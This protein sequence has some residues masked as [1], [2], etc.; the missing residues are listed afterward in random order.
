MK[1]AESILPIKWMQ[2]LCFLAGLYAVAVTI[3]LFVETAKPLGSRDFHQFWYAGH[4]IIQGR[5][6][7]EAFFAGEPPALPVVYLDGVTIEQYPIAQY[8]LEITP[9][10]TPMMLLLLTPFS[11][12]SWYVAKWAFLVLNLILMLVT[13]WL[14][15][16]HFPFRRIKLSLI[17][18]VLIFLVYFDL[19]ATR[20]AI[21]N[22]QTTLLVFLLMILA[23][24]YADRSWRTAGFTLGIALSKYSLS[25]PVFLFLFY[26]RNFKVLLVAI[27]IQ[28]LGVL[29]VALATATSPLTIII[30]NIQLFF[31]LFDQPGIHFS[32]WFE[33]FSDN[34]FV[35]L[36]PVLVLTLLIFVP[37]VLWLRTL[38]PS[39]AESEAVVDFHLLTILFIWTLL[40]AYHRLYDTLIILFFIVLV[41]KGM[42]TPNLWNLTEK[43]RN[44]LLAFM[45]TIP[46]ILILPARI[47]G[48]FLPNYYGRNGDFVTTCILV[49]MLGF[50]VI[51]LRRFLEASQPQQYMS[52]VDSHEIR[53]NSQ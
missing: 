8:D 7:Y 44:G 1:T 15:I 4:F 39:D 11:Y 22:G 47:V 41:F 3:Y 43:E 51:L 42:A 25:L 35:S 5:D 9:S 52:K 53:I 29:G 34:P 33:V 17:D 16:R 14:V 37:L 28:L 30:E 13:G 49:L 10:N 40:I 32:R 12:F 50:S 46:A 26:K 48:R 24:I 21:E 36:I 31:R 38:S 20:I 27:A 19:S 45:A 2:I 23:L 18:E 6:P